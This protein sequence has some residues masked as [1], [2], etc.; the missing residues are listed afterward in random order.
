M[1]T[2]N[3]ERFLQAQINSLLQQTWKNFEIV[4]SDDASTDG[5]KS[6]LQGY[7]SDPRFNIHYQKENLGSIVNFEF[8][9]QQAKGDYLAFSDQDDLWLPEKI[10]KL[11]NAI[12]DKLLVYCDSLLVDEDGNSLHKKLSQLRKM[13][14]VK[15][16]RGFIMSNV[17]WGHAMMIRKELLKDV[18][19]IPKG[20]P[21]DIWF[22]FKATTLSGIVYLDE[23]LTQY[24]QHSETVTTTIAQKA[25]TRPL[26]K[27]YRDFEARLYWIGIMGGHDGSDFY[28]T[29]YQLYERKS[30]GKMVWSLFRFMLA[31][32]AALF[33][34]T[35]KSFLS[36]VIEIRK[37][38]RGER[39]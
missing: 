27:R 37:E 22:A 29:L 16:T 1:C 10:E 5:T 25:A 24:R 30:K 26:E 6:I 32:Q 33:Q 38:S 36:R 7:E 23:V 15:D 13:G 39:R 14:N 31:N 18:L 11:Y 4:I 19:P 20:V 3:G 17:V 12:G 8:A 28:R 2:Y 9:T 34:F 35:N 21:H